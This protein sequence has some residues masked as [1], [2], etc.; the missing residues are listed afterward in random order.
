MKCK[1]CKREIQK[2]FNLCPYCGLRLVPDATEIKVP[3]PKRLANGDYQGQP[4]YNGKRYTVTAPTLDEYKARAREIKRGNIP[5]PE[6]EYK[7]VI[8][9]D[10]LNDFV[11]ASR[12][13]I[14]ETT[15]FNYSRMARNRFPDAVDCDL[16]AIDWQKLVDRELKTCKPSTV[17][18]AWAFVKA[19]LKHAGY[20]VPKVKASKGKADTHYLDDTE[21]IKLMNAVRGDPLEPAVI[22]LLHSLR[23]GELLALDVSD[24]YDGKIH[25]NKTMVR[26]EGGWEIVEQ[27]KTETS[28]REIPVFCD[29]LYEVLPNSGRIYTKA[30][31]YLTTQIK[32]LCNRAGVTECTA[33]D[34]RRS[35]AS[36]AY[37]LNVPERDI[38][39]C[40]G[41]SSPKVMNECYILL[42]AKDSEKRIQPLKNYFKFT[43]E[44]SQG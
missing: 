23:R 15:F 12:G 7:P 13:T 6:P 5:A 31:T 28:T 19:A 37:F 20:D 4:M 17:F 11:E 22:L 16:E 34:L 10:V 14:R 26:T 30:P 36:L 9:A 27:T 44:Q 32:E 24:I 2:D 42:Y 29:R 21:I 1:K 35:F 39:Q 8:L 25:V 3:E 33:H 43:T 18:N 41:W 40:G 38:M